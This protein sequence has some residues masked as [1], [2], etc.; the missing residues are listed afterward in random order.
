MAGRPRRAADELAG[1]V[2]ANCWCSVQVPVNH[3]EVP[4]K[5]ERVKESEMPAAL[6]VMPD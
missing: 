2:P 5:P 4:S 3:A 1:G 6:G